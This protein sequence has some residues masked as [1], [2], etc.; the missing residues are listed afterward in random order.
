[1]KSG[2][3]RHRVTVQSLTV[4][5]DEYGAP[6]E[7][8]TTM[9]TVWVSIE[10]LEGR[11]YFAARQVNAEVTGRIRMRY[12]PGVLPSMRVLYGTRTFNILSIINPDERKR[13]TELMVQ[14]V[15]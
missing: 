14:E 5:Q 11:E 8:W 3:L 13:M 12:L 9:A 2:Q 1:M 4:T 6:V 15:I 10:P 7:T